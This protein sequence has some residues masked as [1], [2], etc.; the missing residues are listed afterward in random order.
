MKTKKPDIFDYTSFRDYLADIFGYLKS[1][2]SKY[3]HRFIANQVGASSAGWFSNVLSGRIN[4]TNIYVIRLTKLLHLNNHERDYLELLI[5]YEQAG[6]TEEKKMYVD[7]ILT[8]KGV[9]PTVIN[10]DQ[11]DFYNNW[12]ISAIRELLFIYD[13]KD[14]YKELAKLLN[15][16]IKIQEAKKAIQ[17]LLTLNMITCTSKGLYKPIDPV[18]RKN[19][20]FKTVHWAN[21]MR[22]KGKLGI[23]AIERF[24]KEERDISEV[25][26]PLSQ[27]SFDQVK[28]DIKILRKKI[29][30]LSEKDK[31]RN[32]V[33]QCN[34]QLFPLTK[35]VKNHEKE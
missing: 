14:D 4:L 23:E 1:Q 17:I 2:N 21:L 26:V 12:Y 31:N 29:L 33:Y 11:F 9:K 6:S 16:Q 30:S 5:N 19:P 28:E 7:K 34:I 3:S 27:K 22:I 13:F 25:Y 18:I 24:Q 15:P 20:N 10:R 32:T 8:S 35:R